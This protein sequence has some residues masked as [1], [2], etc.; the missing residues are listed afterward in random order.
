MS[1]IINISFDSIRLNIENID[2][3]VAELRIDGCLDS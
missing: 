1:A 2:K 3:E